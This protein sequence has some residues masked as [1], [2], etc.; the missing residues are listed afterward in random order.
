MAREKV[1]E[2][3]GYA[4]HFAVP[5]AH[6]ALEQIH[7]LAPAL[8][9]DIQGAVMGAPKLMQWIV[10]RCKFERDGRMVALKPFLDEVCPDVA[11]YL[12]LGMEAVQEVFGPFSAAFNNDDHP[13]AKAAQSWS[14]VLSSGPMT[15]FSGDS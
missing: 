2:I 7:H 9:G 12:A 4:V 1:F 15:G 13:L 14:S 3:N 6:Q 5:S 10:D 11:V 8:K